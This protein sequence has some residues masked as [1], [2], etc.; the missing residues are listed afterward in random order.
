MADVYLCGLLK[1]IA[2]AIR[3]KLGISDGIKPEEFP[4]KIL[5]MEGTGDSEINTDLFIK[6][7]E[8]TVTTIEA[9]DISNLT[10]IKEYAFIGCDNLTSITLPN[11]I[12]SID[13]LAFYG[14]NNLTTINVPWS[15]GQI[16]GA[17]WS[18]DNA[19]INYNYGG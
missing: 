15:E 16:S 18:A 5:S 14:C 17:P 10:S 12:S 19:T 3:E 8:G 9:S 4:D 2:D 13:M 11:T 6:L 7:V 1:D